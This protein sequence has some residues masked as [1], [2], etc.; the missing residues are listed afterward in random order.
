[1]EQTILLCENSYIGILSGIYEAYKMKCEHQNTMIQ[2]GEEENYQLFSKYIA[3]EPNEEYAIKVSRSVKEKLG[4]QVHIQIGRALASCNSQRGN[5]VY[6]TIVE[7]LSGKGKRVME[8]L[9]NDYV[10]RTMELSRNV[11]MEVHHLYG[12]LRFQELDSKIM[13]ATIKPKNNILTLLAPHF[14]DRFCFENFIIY[15]EGRGMYI[16]HPSGQ[17]WYLVS[18]DDLEKEIDITYSEAEIEVQTLFQHFCHSIA[19]KER[20]N[21]DLQRN[22]LPFR[23]RDNMVEFW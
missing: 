2:V 19:I 3:I 6:H 18:K 7:G 9:Q 16:F 10:R 12:F 14:T 23:F 20:K 22:M 17:E 1:M 21:L 8:F 5:V 15:D 4:E 11:W 13:F